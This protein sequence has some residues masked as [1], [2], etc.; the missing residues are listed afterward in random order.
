VRRGVVV[1]SFHIITLL[2]ARIIHGAH[3]VKKKKKKKFYRALFPVLLP[4]SSLLSLSLAR[5]R[6]FGLSPKFKI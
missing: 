4:F 6:G 5:A 3:R 2:L 1:A